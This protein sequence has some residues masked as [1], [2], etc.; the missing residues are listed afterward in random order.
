M[1]TVGGSLRTT[2]RPFAAYRREPGAG[3]C[4]GS[5]AAGSARFA[6][7]LA[8]VRREQRGVGSSWLTAASANALPP[9]GGNR[10]RLGARSSRSNRKQP[11]HDTR[12]QTLAACWW[13]GNWEQLGGASS[14]ELR[15]DGSS[16]PTTPVINPF[17]GAAAAY[18]EFVFLAWSWG[19]PIVR[20]CHWSFC[21]ARTRALLV[22][23]AQDLPGWQKG[24][25]GT[26]TIRNDFLAGT[27]KR[28]ERQ[29]R[30]PSK[31]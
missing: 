9:A 19:V 15:A 17:G 20:A 29:T 5:G 8:A 7:S 26:V 31:G 27:P 24:A 28:L 2:P 30:P 11:V 4:W 3:S 14:R 12:N 18:P 16:R 25:E 22:P 6:T 21:F 10:E 1:G 13:A 23:A